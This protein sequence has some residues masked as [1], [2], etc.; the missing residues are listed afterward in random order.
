MK[1][2]IARDC[3][4]RSETVREA[5]ETAGGCDWCG[6]ARPSGKLFRY[7]TEADGLRVRTHWHSGLFCA[8]GCHDAY[9]G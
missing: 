4:A 3:F 1:A 8:K 9:H 7:G 5:V 6:N 2:T